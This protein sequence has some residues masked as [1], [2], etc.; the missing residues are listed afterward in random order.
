MAQ[1][2]VIWLFGLSGAGKTT[3]AKSLSKI[4]IQKNIQH[5]ILDGDE[6]RNTV[7]KD[8]GFSNEDRKENIRRSAEFAKLVSQ[9]DINCICAFITPLKMLRDIVRT[10]L[11]E[12]VMIFY[13]D[14][15]LEECA[16]RDVKGFYKKALNNEIPDFTGI[17]ANFEFPENEPDVI[18][19]S[20]ANRTPDDC[21][22]EIF[23]F[24]EKNKLDKSKI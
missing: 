2:K 17:T 10:T 1:K 20:T 8:L 15:P 4:F 14:T 19:I 22:N 13:I 16:K 23:S 9:Q 3:I 6:I 21:A 18:K 5:L 12:N 11:S 24:I 7:N